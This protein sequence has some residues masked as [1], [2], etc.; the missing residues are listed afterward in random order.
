MIA[1]DKTLRAKGLGKIF[2]NSRMCSAEVGKKLSTVIMK[3]PWK[4]L[5]TGA[6]NST[7]LASK[8]PNTTLSTIA[9]LKKIC[10]NC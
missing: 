1:C 8:N 9:E 3:K 2:T 10:R 5:K 7:G 6:K 4:A